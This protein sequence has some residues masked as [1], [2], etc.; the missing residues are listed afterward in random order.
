MKHLLRNATALGFGLLVS[1]A[2][3]A[4]AASAEP[5]GTSVIGQAGETQFF[6]GIRLWASEWDMKSL[7]RQPIVNPANPTQILFRDQV[8]THVSELTFV[9]MPTIGARFGKFMTSATYTVPTTYASANGAISSVGRSELDVIGGYFVA[10]SV[11]VSVGYKHGK[12]DRLVPYANVD[13]SIKIDALL[14]GV[15]GSAP[16]AD[17]LSLY[18]NLAYGL[19]RQKSKLSDTNGDTSHRATYTIG[20]VGFNYRLTDGNKLGFLQGLSAS[21]GYRVQTYTA[22]D[23]AFGT[24]AADN[25]TLL[26]ID[27]S[28]IRSTTSG[29]IL[30]LIGS[31]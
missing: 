16:L 7:S 28:N 14:L 5:G 31:F 13:S 29:F 23:L 17:R 22:K 30:A 12:T 15:S 6:A 4:Q 9:P 25:Q 27:K 1:T 8:S 2:T 11:L 26:E 3:L 24:Y 18:G 21:A 20:E 10:P 19:G